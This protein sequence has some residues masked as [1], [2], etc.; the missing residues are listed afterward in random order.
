MHQDEELKKA[1]YYG[2]MQ[3]WIIL[4]LGQGFAQ[5]HCK[6]EQILAMTASI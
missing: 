5:S 6:E 1:V 4:G 2:E 3:N